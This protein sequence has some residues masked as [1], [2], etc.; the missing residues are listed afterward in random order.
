M[1][2]ILNVLGLFVHLARDLFRAGQKRRPR[3]ALRKKSGTVRTVKRPRTD[4]TPS[5]REAV[6]QVSTIDWS[7]NV[8]K[9]ATLINNTINVCLKLCL[10]VWSLYG[11]AFVNQ[12]KGPD[13]PL[14]KIVDLLELALAPKAYP[15]YPMVLPD[16]GGFSLTPSEEAT[17]KENHSRKPGSH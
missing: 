11:I 12:L 5:A 17:L 4:H 16:L 15:T 14:L 1:R 9:T 2:L 7:T 10:I 8:A 13:A 3:S 6:S